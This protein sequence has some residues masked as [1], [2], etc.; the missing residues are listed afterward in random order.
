MTTEK[1]PYNRTFGRGEKKSVLDNYLNLQ[2]H[3][4]FLWQAIERVNA[5]EDLNQV[6]KDYGWIADPACM[7]SKSEEAA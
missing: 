2:N 3:K 1:R 7:S 5:G 6:M 4:K